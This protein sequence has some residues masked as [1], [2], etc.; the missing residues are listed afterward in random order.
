L[1]E[2]NTSIGRPI[3]ITKGEGFSF[4][5]GLTAGIRTDM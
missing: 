5:D 2:N 3:A 4:A 1:V